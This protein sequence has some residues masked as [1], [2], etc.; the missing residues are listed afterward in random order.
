YPILR[1]T[2]DGQVELALWWL[3]ATTSEDERADRRRR[4]KKL[5]A[6]GQLQV[7]EALVLPDT[8]LAPPEL[9][10]RNLLEGRRISREFGAAPA[11]TLD[12]SDIFGHP[13][14]I[15]QIM[16]GFDLRYFLFTRG[17]GDEENQIGPVFRWQ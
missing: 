10:I 3:E 12:F 1:Y 11:Q 5:V 7:G 4:L 2:L 16:A 9:L 6:C 14:Q 17:L 15:P 13:A 8:F